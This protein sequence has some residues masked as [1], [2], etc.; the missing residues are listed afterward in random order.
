MLALSPCAVEALKDIIHL[1]GRDEND[2]DLKY[3][4]DGLHYSRI[5]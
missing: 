2:R 1:P 3:H 4:P 5:T